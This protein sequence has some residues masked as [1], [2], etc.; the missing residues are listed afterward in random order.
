MGSGKYETASRGEFDPLD[1]VALAHREVGQ[2]NIRTGTAF[3]LTASFLLVLSG[4]TLMQMASIM[5]TIRT[6]PSMK[7]ESPVPEGGWSLF[8]ANR[9]LLASIDGLSDRLEHENPLAEAIRP[10][11]QDLLSRMGAGTEQVWQGGSGWLFFKRDIDH[12]TGLDFLSPRQL[13]RR[14]ATGD[15]L[16]VPPE[17]DPRPAILSFAEELERRDIALI[18]MPTP[19]KPSVQAEHLVTGLD[20]GMPVFNPSR[21]ALLRELREAGVLVFDPW[22]VMQKL[23]RT[24]KTQLYLK[25]DTHWRPG[26]V[27]LV[28]HELGAFIG[29]HVGLAD[30]EPVFYQRRQIE[31]SN[32]GDIAMLL[33]LDPRETPYP[34]ETV[35]VG[36]VTNL[37]GELWRADHS[38]EVLVLG[39]SFSNVF[40]LDAMG[41]GEA[42]G[43]VE[44]LS[45]ALERPVDRLARNDDGAFASRQMLSDELT[46]GRDR[47]SGKRVVV[48]QFAER[49]LSQGDWKQIDLDEATVP[50]T[51]F[52]EPVDAEPILV[53]GTIA[54]MAPPPVPHRVPYRDHI[55]AL[56]LTQ[57]VVDKGAA[58]GTEA[59]LYIWS[60]R[61]KV[62]TQA[63]RYR[64][65][66]TI[67]LR[68]TPWTGVAGELERINR[69]EL[70]DGAIRFVEPWW[71][72][73]L[74][75]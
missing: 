41:W 44:H 3:A 34:P 11:A 67:R 19:V 47:L 46:R 1:R 33:D 10:T 70:Q 54:E 61:D 31:V 25:T 49:E 28:A 56:H 13:A 37:S 55:V 63:A 48:Y 39:D 43:F 17:P 4:G 52:L 6:V 36:Q 75:E 64:S 5:Q 40:S 66:Q 45:D 20:P 32:R 69:A 72:E 27:A 24:G 23:K 58:T 53:R 15:T 7:A 30:V 71:A 51:T 60:M 26:T 68:L 16:T 59:F 12:V 18:V 65:G 74:G 38:A 22:P 8:A 50:K 73:P 57:I 14:A 21:E 35:S 29:E 9:R 62:L 2:T 42:G